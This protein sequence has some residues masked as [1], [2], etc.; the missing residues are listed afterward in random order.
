MARS[1]PGAA[2]CRL[3][4]I[5]NGLLGNV[6][7]VVISSMVFGKTTGCDVTFSFGF[8]TAFKKPRYVSAWDETRLVSLLKIQRNHHARQ[9]HKEP[10]ELPFVCNSRVPSA[11]VVEKCNHT[12]VSESGLTI[13]HGRD[14]AIASYGAFMPPGIS[15]AQFLHEYSKMARLVHVDTF[16]SGRYHNL[17]YYMPCLGRPMVS[18]HLRTGRTTFDLK[19]STHRGKQRQCKASNESRFDIPLEAVKAAT[20][21]VA[22]RHKSLPGA[23]FVAFDDRTHPDDPRYKGFSALDAMKDIFPNAWYSRSAIRALWAFDD[24]RLLSTSTA[25]IAYEYSSFSWTAAQMAGIPYYVLRCTEKCQRYT[26]RQCTSPEVGVQVL[27]EVSFAS[28]HRTGM[29]LDDHEAERRRRPVQ[30]AEPTT[31]GQIRW[32]NDG[33]RPRRRPDEK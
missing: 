2:A 14:V 19:C 26:C 32:R 25:V 9:V 33:C 5:A 6:L 1:E 3:H 8:I 12:S 13:V 10:D 21:L 18:A 24:H 27:S 22:S 20:R 16:S 29:P 15:H 11:A 30:T 23:L 7:D 17:S 31:A 4:C 28:E